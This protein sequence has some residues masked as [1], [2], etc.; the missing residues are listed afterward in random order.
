MGGVIML[1][2]NMIDIAGMISGI[3]IIITWGILDYISTK[4]KK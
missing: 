2:M 4:N 3:I 1:R